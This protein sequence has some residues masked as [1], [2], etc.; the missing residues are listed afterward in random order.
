MA[1]TGSQ[2]AE[3]SQS[4]GVYRT[5]VT[6]L[7]SGVT[8][9][10]VKQSAPYS[11]HGK[12][13][14]AS[15]L[16]SS[17]HSSSTSMHRKMNMPSRTPVTNI[18]GNHSLGVLGD[19]Y[20]LPH[21]KDKQ[22]QL[23]K[24]GKHKGVFTHADKLTM[25]DSGKQQ[26]SLRNFDN[27]AISD[28]EKQLAHIYLDL[29]SDYDQ[30]DRS[31][32]SHSPANTARSSAKTYDS[33]ES[34]SDVKTD[35]LIFPMET[36]SEDSQYMAQHDKVKK[37]VCER[38]QFQISSRTHSTAKTQR[39][40]RARN[41]STSELVFSD[42]AC[43]AYRVQ[44]QS[45][46]NCT[47]T[48]DDRYTDH[49]LMFHTQNDRSDAE[50]GADARMVREDVSAGDWSVSGQ[51]YSRAM[52][53]NVWR[54]SCLV[55]PPFKFNP[56]TDCH[57]HYSPRRQ[58]FAAVPSSSSSSSCE[59]RS[60]GSRHCSV[61]GRARLGDRAMRRLRKHGQASSFL[62]TDTVGG[63]HVV[64]PGDARQLEPA[65]GNTQ[66]Y[67]E[68]TLAFAEA[69]RKKRRQNFNATAGP[70]KPRSTFTVSARS[71][72]CSVT[73]SSSC[74]SAVSSLPQST[75]RSLLRSS[76][77]SGRHSY[78]TSHLASGG[79]ADWK[80]ISKTNYCP[81]GDTSSSSFNAVSVHMD[82]SDE[83]VEYNN[84][85]P[86]NRLSTDCGR[87]VITD[88]SG[89]VV[90]S[91]GEDRSQPAVRE[92]HEIRSTPS[93]SRICEPG[94]T[95]TSKDNASLNNIIFA[96]NVSEHTGQ[97]AITKC[98][99]ITSCGQSD[100]NNAPFNRNCSV[101]SS[102]DCASNADAHAIDTN[103]ISPGSRSSSMDHVTSESE[104][105]PLQMFRNWW[106][107][108]DP[109]NQHSHSHSHSQLYQVSTVEPRRRV[110]AV[111]Q[112]PTSTFDT[113]LNRHRSNF[114]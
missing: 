35:A 30:P 25:P 48:D 8:R 2:H 16:Q 87:L 101:N 12:R 10:P 106:Q 42:Q 83:R 71:R 4:R 61:L 1:C 63:V 28:S 23:S 20:Q 49:Q 65:A 75:A 18:F 104:V 47:T 108:A 6:A 59:E 66:Q 95:D 13:S 45:T 112:K 21:T 11:G 84:V 55:N 111:S 52:W 92:A 19:F 43:Y 33:F 22:F 39:K 96:P 17:A 58:H 9:I 38:R 86:T 91:K 34:E 85:S 26:G 24:T 94:N 60:R 31:K 103:R 62:P 69:K 53:E 32:H 50:I 7:S 68:A 41:L 93:K 56:K 64:R 107:F 81:D 37:T 67:L 40:R 15:S 46:N 76:P 27:L 102:S 72:G 97:A 29:T 70:E 73:S 113:G 36:S 77:P 51:T 109:H 14:G 88:K 100:L 105:G 80:D 74:V 5:F 54:E 79:Q 99:V 78:A 3:I 110:S 90:H 82:T 57:H 89:H 98:P 114:F 44:Q